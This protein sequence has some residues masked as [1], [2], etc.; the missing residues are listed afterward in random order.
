MGEVVAAND[1]FIMAD[2]SEKKCEVEVGDIVYFG[3]SHGTEIKHDGE[4]YLV[5]SEEFILCK[6]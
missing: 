4:T 2:G 5:I 1:S 6:E 3:K